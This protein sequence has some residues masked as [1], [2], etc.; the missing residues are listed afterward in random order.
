ML[1]LPSEELRNNGIIVALSYYHH[2]SGLFFKD[3]ASLTYIN[4]LWIK[5]LFYLLKLKSIDII[6]KNLE[7]KW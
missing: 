2:A 5:T 1:P 4:V 3:S 7:L 6:T